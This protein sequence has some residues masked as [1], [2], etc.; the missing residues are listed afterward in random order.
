MR[1]LISANGAGTAAGVNPSIA[2][3][4]LEGDVTNTTTVNVSDILAV[5]L[6]SGQAVSATNFLNDVT[7]SG[8]TINVSDI[9][10]VRLK[11]GVN[12]P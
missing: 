10:A 4:F 1:L 5:R 2:V 7:V 9:L 8:G 12:L 6:A 3:A 11:S